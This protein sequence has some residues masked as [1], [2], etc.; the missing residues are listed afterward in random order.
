[1]FRSEKHSPIPSRTLPHLH[2]SPLKTRQWPRNL[3]FVPEGAELVPTQRVVPGGEGGGGGGGAGG[4]PLRSFLIAG[5]PERIAWD[6]ANVRA[7]VA[8]CGGLCPGLNTVV[9]E[10]VMCLHYVYGVKPGSVF[11]IPNG[12]RGFYEGDEWRTLTP[13]S[14]S[15][16]HEMGGTVL[17]SSRGGFDLDKIIGAL[18]AKNINIVF[19]VG[20]DGTH[21][22]ALALLKG[23]AERKVRLTVVGVPKTIDNDIDIIDRSFGFDTAV[24]QAV[25]PITCAHTEA[26]AAKN[27]VGLVKLM[28]R[29]AGFIAM[30]ASLAS[31]NVNITLIPEAP[32][33]LSTLL[34]YLEKRLAVRD[35]CVIVVAEGAESIEMKEAKAAAAAAGSARKDESGNVLF[36]DVGVYLRDSITAHFKK[37]GK[38]ASLK[39]IDPSYIIRSSPPNAADSYLC[40]ALA[41]N[42]VHGAFAGRTGF[43]VGTVDN[44]HVWLPI[45]LISSLPPRQVDV[46]GRIYARLCTM[47]GTPNLAGPTAVS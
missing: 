24:D 47:T 6:P 45:S 31:R 7:A 22:G 19:L 46:T 4:K 15:D 17:G 8:T 39:Y 14:V 25:H 42:A 12:Y 41:F 28:G 35:H 43:T 21:R 20:G 33:R 16:I 36:D 30:Y 13:D 3:N 32:W 11:G 40:T 2:R 34:S 29:A 9:R 23:A 1:L 10:I 37:I 38:P 5:P 18:Q 44:A 26:R 27:G